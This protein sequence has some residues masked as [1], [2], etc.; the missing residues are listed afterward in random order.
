MSD[1]FVLQS[2][3]A[4]PF[5][6]FVFLGHPDPGLCAIDPTLTTFPDGRMRACISVAGKD[7]QF[8]HVREMSKPW[9]YGVGR[10]DIAQAESPSVLKGRI[11][12][13]Y[14]EPRAT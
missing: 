11:L 5:D 4:D 3:T 1:T 14:S 2:K 9:L 6:G 13:Y 12:A 10:A 7:G 8:L